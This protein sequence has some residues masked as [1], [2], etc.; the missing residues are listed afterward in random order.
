MF[1]SRIA[2]RSPRL[3]SLPFNGYE[4]GSNALATS[5]GINSNGETKNTCAMTDGQPLQQKIAQSL[6]C[7]TSGRPRHPT[8]CTS[9]CHAVSR[10]HRNEEL[11]AHGQ[12]TRILI[13]GGVVKG[14]IAHLEAI[15]GCTSLYS[16]RRRDIYRNGWCGA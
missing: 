9:L 11:L 6:E 2:A 14:I 10:N 4:D 8:D 15:R 5:F 16:K 13:T 3:V 12:D 7:G 1:T